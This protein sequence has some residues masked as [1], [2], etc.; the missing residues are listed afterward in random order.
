MSTVT[1]HAAG[2]GARV[3]DLEQ[4]EAD[5]GDLGGADDLARQLVGVGVGAAVGGV[6]EVVE[7]A[8]AGDAGAQHLAVAGERDPVDGFG[9][10][11][12]AFGNQDHGGRDERTQPA[13]R[14]QINLKGL[15][16]AVVDA[17]NAW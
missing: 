2:A 11:D 9:A 5:A 15:E 8:D 7:L 13:R 14:L 4:D 3:E 6:V 17:D 10:A 1:F 12:A 16:I